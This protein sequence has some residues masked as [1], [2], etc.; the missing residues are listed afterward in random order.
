MNVKTMLFLAFAGAEILYGQVVGASISGTVTDESGSPLAA[1]A[2]SVKSVETGAERKLIADDAGRY[3]APSIAVGH[4][5]VSAEKPGFTSQ[6]KTG[7]DLVVGQAT[8]VN[9]TLPVGELTQAITV[10]AAPSPV[11]QST[12]QISGLVS[13]RQIKDLPL[14][15]RSYDQLVSLNAGI[16][17]Y[18]A[19]RSGGGRTSNSSGGSM[20]AVSGWRPQENLFLL[21]GVEYTGASVINN[22]PGGTSGQLL[23]VDAVREF[24][25]VSDTYGAEYGKRPG[26]QVSIVTASVTNDLH[27]TVY[28]FVRNSDLDARNFFDQG[29]IPQFQRNSF[30]GTLEI[31]RASCRER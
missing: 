18:T 11:N 6:V 26:G 7:I 17:N 10:E 28:E 30:G 25:V 5:Q 21:N 1:A 13:E 27:G 8:V 24:N 12:Q 14:N 22:T 19:E 16:V 29:A 9:L 20:F 2:V 23:G 4:Y 31:G 15:G 3:S